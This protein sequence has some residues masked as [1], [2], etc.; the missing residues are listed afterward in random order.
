MERL[1]MI[2]GMGNEELVRCMGCGLEKAG[3]NLEN[4]GFCEEGWQKALKKLYAIEDILGD[5]YGLDRLRELVKADRDGRCVVR[6]CKTGDTVYI[7]G[8]KKIVEAQI[9][10]MCLLE[11]NGDIELLVFFDCDDDCKG[12][13]FNSWHQSHDGEWSCD[14]EYGDGSVKQSDIG[15]T[16]FL[17]CEAAEAALNNR[18]GGTV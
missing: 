8:D 14:G 3:E 13:P 2:D 10:D 7:V 16:V 4:C 18:S 17:T 6:K 11:S 15:K 1:T 9:Q 5:D 12:C